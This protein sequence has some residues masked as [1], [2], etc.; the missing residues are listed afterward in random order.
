MPLSFNC[1]LDH[2]AI[3]RKTNN[4][5]KDRFLFFFAKKVIKNLTGTKYW[6]LTHWNLYVMAMGS[7]WS[8]FQ[9]L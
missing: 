8:S 1:K 7:F 9:G 2:S 3:W 5:R 4:L 6:S